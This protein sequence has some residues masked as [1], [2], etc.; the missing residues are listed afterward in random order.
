MASCVAPGK[1]EDQKELLLK[2]VKID[3]KEHL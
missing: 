3:T 1:L 2:L